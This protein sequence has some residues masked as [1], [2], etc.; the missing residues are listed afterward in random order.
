MESLIE[1]LIKSI[2]KVLKEI[3]LLVLLS[4][5]LSA[6]VSQGTLRKET[7][8]AFLRGQASKQGEVDRL[9]KE[10]AEM[11]LLLREK[12]KEIESER[13]VNDLV[14]DIVD[15]SCGLGKYKTQ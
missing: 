7:E 12:I 9:L 11:D 15:Q 8:A 4:L 13:K 6:C 14:N 10:R 3:S 5:S 2:L 1:Y